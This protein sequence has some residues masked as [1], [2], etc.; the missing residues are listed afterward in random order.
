MPARLIHVILISKYCISYTGFI[1]MRKNMNQRD[2][3]IDIML[4][5]GGYA[6]LGALNRLVDFS[7]WRTKTPQATIRRIVQESRFFFKI[8]PGLWALNECRES[9]LKKLKLQGASEL[10]QENFT[11]SYYQGLLVEIGNM[12][13][14]QTCVPAQDKNK[15]FLETKLG[16]VCSLDAVQDF[17]FPGIMRYAKT[18]DVLWLNER[19]LPSALFEVEH[20]TDIAHSLDKYYELQ[21]FYASFYIVADSSRRN[22]FQDLLSKRTIY[23]SIAKRILFL[24]Y[25][26][27]SKVHSLSKDL[28][29]TCSSLLP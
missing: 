22:Q 28:L 5:N 25:E 20:S 16:N 14:F 9:V 24:S 1:E 3:V 27:L 26:D 11:H 4:K 8:R 2:Q 7:Q 19:N 6:T 23:L 18:V 21:D 15:A 13:H 10:A 12:R 17:T 29:S